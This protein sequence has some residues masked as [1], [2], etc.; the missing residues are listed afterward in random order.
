MRKGFLFHFPVSFIRPKLRRRDAFWAAE[1]VEAT[2][3]VQQEPEVVP[4]QMTGVHNDVEDYS[5]AGLTLRQRPIVLLIK[6]LAARNIITCAEAMGAR[7]G[8]RVYAAGLVLVRHKPGSAKSVM[9]IT[10]EDEARPANIVVWPMRFEKRR[11]IVLGSSMTVLNGRIQREAEVAHGARN[12]VIEVMPS[13]LILMRQFAA[14]AAA[15][16][17]MTRLHGVFY[18]L[19]GVEKVTA[20]DLGQRLPVACFKRHDHLLMLCHCGRPFFRSLVTDE[21]DPLEARLQ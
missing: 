19:P 12:L 10:I 4:C 13:E 18:T 8:R 5:D 14:S 3:A 11:W 9:F 20:Q 7:D 21:A 17:L 16:L 2:I 1:R 6:D 15:V